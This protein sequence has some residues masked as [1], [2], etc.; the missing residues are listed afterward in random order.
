MKKDFLPDY[1]LYLADNTLILGHRN[2]EWTGHGPILE[3][4]IALSNIAL[5]LIGQARYFYQYAASL[6]NRQ[7]D[8]EELTEDTLAYMRDAP[9]F[10]NCLLVEQPN[11]HWGKTTLRQFFFSV[12]Q[13]LLYERL[14]EGADKNIAAICE[15]ALKE[16]SYHVRWS[17]EW[18]LRLGDGTAESNRRMQSALDELAPF[19]PELFIPASYEKKIAD[20]APLKKKWYTTINELLEEATLQALDTE[21]KELPHLS[22]K[23]GQ[24]TTHLYLLLEEMQSVQRAYPGCSW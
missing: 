20:P 17:R 24:H 12:Y 23:E 7:A 14:R 6:L 9:S 5:D 13:S 15:K 21:S 8:E 1:I 22:G 3:Q 2:S 19:V 16:I 4:D 10:K 18:V 11:G